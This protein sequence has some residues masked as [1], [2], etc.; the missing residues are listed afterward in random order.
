MAYDF[1]PLRQ[2]IVDTEEWLRK[3]LAG[4]RTGRATPALLDSVQVEA[5]GAKAPL[6]QVAG[7]SVEDARTLRLSPWDMG[8]I[9]E[10][11][12]AITMAGL[13]VSVS[14]DEKGCR[15]HFPEL[16]AERRGMLVKLVGQKLEEARVAL[17]S[18]RDRVWNDIQKQ[19]RESG[20][21]A[22]EKYRYKEEMEK[23][24]QEGSAS[25]EAVAD[26]KEKE[27]SS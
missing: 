17:R 10:I 1:K 20:I 3:E 21:T 15:V 27:I 2:K 22:D 7:I 18:E 13:G 8:Q 12:K 19:E 23:I 9:K 24:V 26:K 25:F 11:E 6:Q 4:V 14:T 5:Y 16:T